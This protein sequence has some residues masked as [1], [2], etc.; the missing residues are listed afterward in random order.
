MRTLIYVVGV[1][2]AIFWLFMTIHSAAAEES[3]TEKFTKLVPIGGTIECGWVKFIRMPDGLKPQ[4]PLADMPYAKLS[5]GMENDRIVIDGHP[6]VF[7]CPE[8]AQC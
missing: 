8:T 5:I 3:I 4:G 7:K 2:L 1:C 6:C